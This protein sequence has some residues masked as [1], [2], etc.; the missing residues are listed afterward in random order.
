ARLRRASFP[1]Q[2]APEILAGGLPPIAVMTAG[3]ALDLWPAH[4]VPLYAAAWY[5]AELALIGAVRWPLS[6]RTPLVLILRD[7]L[8]PV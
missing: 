4:A 2:F 3:A 1:A 5:G 7:T 6:P 8:L